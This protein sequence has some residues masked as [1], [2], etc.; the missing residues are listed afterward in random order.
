MKNLKYII[1][2]FLLL[3]HFNLYSQE[4]DRSII[5][6]DSET[7]Q[8]LGELTLEEF[9]TLI[10]ASG[11]YRKI[12]ES[13]Y[14]GNVKVNAIV[15]KNSENEDIFL[16]NIVIRYYDDNNENY[17][18]IYIHERFKI[19]ENTEMFYKIKNYYYQV[20]A[21]SLPVLIIILLILL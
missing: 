9:K 20:S 2:S 1:L 7:G 19:K 14:K 3:L 15:E 12:L 16:S 5:L 8:V 11:N 4:Q 10:I 21:F 18:T 13:E 17:K 6:S